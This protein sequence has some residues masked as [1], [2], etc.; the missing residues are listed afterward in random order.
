M[1]QQ[2]DHCIQYLRNHRQDFIGKLKE[3]VSFASVST[4]PE[5]FGDIQRTAEWLACQLMELRMDNVTVFQTARNP[6]VYAETLKA[7]KT[8]PT[9]LIYGH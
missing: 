2:A 9:V 8:A 4:D 3:Y 6:V 7:G 1:S 5:H